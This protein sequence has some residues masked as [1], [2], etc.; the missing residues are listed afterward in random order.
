MN[1]LSYPDCIPDSYANIRYMVTKH[2]PRK[3][4]QMPGLIAYLLYHLHLNE[5]FF[6]RKRFLAIIAGTE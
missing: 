3:M 1:P 4:V 2:L 6:Y 5:F